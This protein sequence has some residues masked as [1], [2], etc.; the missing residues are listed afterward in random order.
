MQRLTIPL[1][2][3]MLVFASASGDAIAQTPPSRPSAQEI[4]AKHL[5]CKKQANAKKLTGAERHQFVIDCQK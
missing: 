2:A 3:M 1:L 5:A 4:A